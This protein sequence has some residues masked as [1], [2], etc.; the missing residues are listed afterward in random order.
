MQSQD[1]N[2]GLSMPDFTC[3][4]TLGVQIKKKV[5]NLSEYLMRLKKNA[6]IRLATKLLQVLLKQLLST[7]FS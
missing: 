5:T 4:A 3:I 2:P 7:L 1:E 6:H